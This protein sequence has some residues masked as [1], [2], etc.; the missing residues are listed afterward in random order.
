MT[1]WGEKIDEISVEE[2]R[3]KLAEVDDDGKAVK[4][5]VAAIAYKQGQSPADIEESFGFSKNNV[6]EWLDRFEERGLE[7]AL[8]DESPPGR[9]SELSDEQ[10]ERFEDAVKNPPED[11]GIDAPAWSTAL[12]QEYL[13]EQF[14]LEFT[15]RHVRR[16]LHDAG[17][18][19]QTPRPQPP[20]ADEEERAE[21]RED[22][23]KT[24]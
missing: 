19:W 1:G 12:A 14:D 18:S 6:Y 10:R 24:D 9:P 20:T 5:L 8:Y 4:R 16:L 2:L 22:I 15:R 23:K 7:D 21:F 11:V 13:R 3:S 17:L